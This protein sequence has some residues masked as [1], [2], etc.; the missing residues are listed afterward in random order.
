MIKR[1]DGRGYIKNLSKE[2]G[3]RK[4]IERLS[5]DYRRAIEKAIER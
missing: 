2:N 1:K 5:E 3:Y 4:V